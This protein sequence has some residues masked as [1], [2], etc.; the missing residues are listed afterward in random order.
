MALVMEPP[1][2]LFVEYVLKYSDK[3]FC[4]QI[5]EEFILCF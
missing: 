5:K 3:S 4:F 2:M 1:K